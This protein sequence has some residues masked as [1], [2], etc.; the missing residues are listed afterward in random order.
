MLLE[1]APFPTGEKTLDG[2]DAPL[3]TG[4]KT[5]DGE[6]VYGEEVD[7]N[8]MWQGDPPPKEP[9]HKKEEP[10]DVIH[11]MAGQ[12][13][14]VRIDEPEFVKK[15]EAEL[16]ERF[17]E[18]SNDAIENLVETAKKM[19]IYFLETTKYAVDI[20]HSKKER[21]SA[22][23]MSYSQ[24]IDKLNILLSPQGPSGEI[25]FNVQLGFGANGAMYALEELPGEIGKFN[26]YPVAVD[27][28]GGISLG[29]P[30]LVSQEFVPEAKT[31]E[32]M[33]ELP[34]EVGPALQVARQKNGRYRWFAMPACTAVINRDGEIDSRDLFD[35]FVDYAES[36]RDYPIL[37]FYHLQDKIRLGQADWVAREG[38]T[39]CA[40]GLFDD[41][42]EG[43]AA[44]ISIMK[45]PDYWGL[46]ISYVTGKRPDI[47]RTEIGNV[48]VYKEGVNRYISLLPEAFASSE[49]TNITFE[50]VNRMNP[51]IKEALAKLTDGDDE[52]LNSLEEKIDDINR[53][54]EDMVSREKK[55]IVE[56]EPAEEVDRAEDDKKDDMPDE[57]KEK[58]PDVVKQVLS[59][60][61][62]EAKVISIVKSM[63]KPAPEK[64]EEKEDEEKDRSLE[65]ISKLYEEIATLNRPA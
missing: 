18:L 33:P 49:F 11:K 60:A 56:E 59:S 44:A 63:N 43:K 21:S 47:E 61:E 15:V 6:D 55:D 62:F 27:Q 31:V 37:D 38:N 58:S 8:E 12:M 35:S 13:A 7:S 3:P 2:E 14:G 64:K 16:K 17:P 57:K 24:L 40:S 20:N 53:A 39:Y 52:L 25:L 1:N 51:K 23:L 5:L 4:E 46:S 28:S 30:E 26:M 19:R 48:P 41:T 22:V 42:P 65:D 45:N 32:V 34:L 54:T 29:D 10:H 36:T 50:E 9:E